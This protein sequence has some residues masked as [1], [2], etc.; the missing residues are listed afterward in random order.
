MKHKSIVILGI[1]VLAAILFL[2][3]GFPKPD[4]SLSDATISGSAIENNKFADGV[5]VPVNKET[6]SFSFDV[7]GPGKSHIGTFNEYNSYLITTKDEI[8]GLKGTIIVDS[9]TTEIGKLTEHL[10][11][12]DFFDAARFPEIK[13][14]SQEIKDGQMTGEL[15]FRGVTKTISFPVTVG[16]SGVKSTF[17]LETAEFGMATTFAEEDVVINFDF[18]E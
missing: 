15:T 2:T 8:V 18:R 14:V 17:V 12:E 4:D 3:F 16:E 6:S 13:F 5:E 11:S 9:V 7:F 10:K 1:I